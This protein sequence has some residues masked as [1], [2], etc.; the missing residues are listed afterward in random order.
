M[1]CS[2]A[3]AESLLTTALLPQCQM[4]HRNV[5]LSQYV[6]RFSHQPENRWQSALLP[7][8]PV[9]HVPQIE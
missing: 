9:L 8:L 7:N 1:A 3:V 6:V 2:T 4:C 5:T